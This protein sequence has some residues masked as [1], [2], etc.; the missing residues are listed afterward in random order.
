MRVGRGEQTRSDLEC[1]QRPRCPGQQRDDARTTEEGE[2][3]R[4][5][6]HAFRADTRCQAREHDD[7]E[8]LGSG[9]G[10]GL[11]VFVGRGIQHRGADETPE[12]ARSH[13]YLH[14]VITIEEHAL[15]HDE[16]PSCAD[17]P[18]WPAH[19]ARRIWE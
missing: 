9:R 7:R 16:T 17:W 15:C 13:R 19:S 2:G 11:D 12:E 14:V 18:Y 6:T 4:T 8:R 10:V 3:G 1:D 5:A